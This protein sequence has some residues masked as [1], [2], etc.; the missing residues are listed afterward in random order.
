M[1]TI[2]LDTQ[3]LHN[4][5]K[6]GHAYYVEALQKALQELGGHTYIGCE[7]EINRDLRT[8]ER[9]LW[10]QIQL[11]RMARKQAADILCTTAFS[12]PSRT[13]SGS[14]KRV[15][16]VHDLSLIRFPQNMRGISGWFLR[17]FVPRSFKRAEHL[18]AISQTTKQDLVDLLQV[19]E[20][21]ISVVHSGVDPFYAPVAAKEAE[22]T[23][24]RFGLKK[25]FMLFVGTLEPRKNIPFLIRA[26]ASV[27]KERD[28]QLVLVGKKGWQYDEIFSAIET[29]GLQ[30]HVI[31]LGYVSNEEKRALYSLASMFVYASMYE[32]F[33]MPILEAMACG[34]PVISANTSCLPEVA[35]NAAILLPLDES[36]WKQEVL[37][38]VDTPTL[39]AEY[40]EKGKAR[41][42]TFTWKRTAEGVKAVFDSLMVR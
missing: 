30:N 21:K 6:T 31:E 41:A 27:L 18:I 14:M 23:S 4:P 8:H 22:I 35:S 32:G 13:L 17:N 42:A 19:P 28:M 40:S 15:A 11:P 16:I 2:V 39:R 7:P 36:M 5:Q 20:S 9:F 10:D 25:P 1:A 38:M 29:H 12:V 34:C 33:G 37:K 26:M 3:P 24:A